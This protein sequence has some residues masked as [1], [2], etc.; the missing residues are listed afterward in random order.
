MS[1]SSWVG[2]SATGSENFL[3][4]HELNLGFLQYSSSSS[5][6]IIFYKTYFLILN[7]EPNALQWTRWG[8]L[9]KLACY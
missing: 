9:F 4:S 6:R 3:D 8:P 5:M 7:V 1:L 2:F